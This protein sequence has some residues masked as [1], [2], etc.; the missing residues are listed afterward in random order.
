MDLRT[1]LRTGG[2]TAA[3][4][5]GKKLALDDACELLPEDKL[6]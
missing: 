5:V 6:Q 1:V 3:E 2:T 4:D